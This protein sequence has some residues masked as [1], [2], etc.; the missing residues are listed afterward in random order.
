[1]Q[2][3]YNAVKEFTEGSSG[4]KCPST[5]SKMSY[6]EVKFIVKMVLSEITELCQTVTES[7]NDALGMMV[8]CLGVDPSKQPNNKNDIEIIADQADAMVDA[9]YYMLNAAAKKGIDLSAVFDVV[10]QANMAKRDPITGKFKR[11]EDGKVLKPPGWKPANITRE[12][13]RQMKLKKL[14]KN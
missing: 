5:P 12:I 13:E 9:W 2:S 10:H 6:D 7:H 14:N 1:M 4:K 8:D 3:N 11:R